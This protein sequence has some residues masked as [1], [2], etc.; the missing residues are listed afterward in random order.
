MHTAGM[1][2]D[3]Q[4][5]SKLWGLLVCILLECRMMGKG[6]QALRLLA[7]IMLE[8]RRMGKGVQSLRSSSMYNAGIQEDG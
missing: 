1:Q 7:C 8:Y 6:I 4:G 5:G 3:G 2:E